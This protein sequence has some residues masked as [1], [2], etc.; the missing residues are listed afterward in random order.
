M[1]IVC[2]HGKFKCPLLVKNYFN[3]FGR[4]VAVRVEC[5]RFDPSSGS[6]HVCYAT[7]RPHVLDPIF[8]CL[9]MFMEGSH[10]KQ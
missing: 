7:S 1:V 10:I 8:S 5:T 3:S 2:Y 6:C 9:L 4:A